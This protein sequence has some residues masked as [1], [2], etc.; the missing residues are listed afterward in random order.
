LI[1]LRGERW[2][3]ADKP[4]VPP[5]CRFWGRAARERVGQNRTHLPTF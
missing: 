2:T 4:P 5:N 1:R 3:L